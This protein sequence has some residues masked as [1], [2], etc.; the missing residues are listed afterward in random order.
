MS[1]TM[2]TATASRT[3]F[4]CL[5]ELVVPKYWPESADVPVPGPGVKVGWVGEPVSTDVPV[6]GPGV[7]VGWVGGPGLADVPVSEVL[8]GLWSGLE[9]VLVSGIEDFGLV[10]RS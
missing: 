1:S 5:A 4:A 2:V 10:G 3:P 7:N 8:E 9:D 6:S